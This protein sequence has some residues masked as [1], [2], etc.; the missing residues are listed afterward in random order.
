MGN[1]EASVPFPDPP[2]Q[3]L[4]AKKGRALEF[5]LFCAELEQG[6][7]CVGTVPY[8]HTRSMAPCGATPLLAPRAIR[9]LT[10][11]LSNLF[12]EVR[13]NW[14]KCQACVRNAAGRTSSTTKPAATPSAPAAAPSSR[15]TSSSRRSPSR[16]RVVAPPQWSASSSLR[17]VAFSLLLF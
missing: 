3:V 7:A 5:S 6:R 1:G 16:N 10:Q 2:V 17:K 9:V 15:T 4:C 11:H 8:A 14:R 13:T 12:A